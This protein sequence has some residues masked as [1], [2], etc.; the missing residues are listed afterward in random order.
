MERKMA[1]AYSGSM[2]TKS[3]PIYITTFK[4]AKEK[5]MHR[6]AVIKVGIA[7]RDCIDYITGHI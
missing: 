2:K 4:L 1:I 5:Y 7:G 3:V 6:S